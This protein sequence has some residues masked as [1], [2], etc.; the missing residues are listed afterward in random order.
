LPA[1]PNASVSNDAFLAPFYNVGASA[2]PG[3]AAI[4]GSGVQFVSAAA[5]AGAFTNANLTT[6]HIKTTIVYFTA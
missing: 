5:G 1:T 4:A 3:Y 6:V 2:W